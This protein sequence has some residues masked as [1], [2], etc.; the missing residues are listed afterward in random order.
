VR[1]MLSQ[2]RIEEDCK[3]FEKVID[4]MILEEKQKIHEKIARTKAEVE[5]IGE[6][7]EN[8]LALDKDTGE[9]KKS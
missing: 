3:K 4:Q 9:K 5:N 6:S 1:I 7:V 8:N 2:K